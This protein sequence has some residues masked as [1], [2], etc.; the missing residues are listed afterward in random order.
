MSFTKVLN[1]RVEAFVKRM[2]KPSEHTNIRAALRSLNAAETSLLTSCGWIHQTPVGWFHPD[3]TA[4]ST[5]VSREQAIRMTR[6][7]IMQSQLI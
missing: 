6:Y 5:V 1:D 7:A 4:D 3:L 2:G